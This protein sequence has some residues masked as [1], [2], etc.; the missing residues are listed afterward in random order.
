[1]TSQTRLRVLPRPPRGGPSRAPLLCVPF[2]GGG[3]TAY[4][5][6]HRLLPRDIL[7][8]T[9][10]LP[11]REA[12]FDEELPTDL[13]TLAA[14]IAAEVAPHLTG[15]FVLFGHSMGAVVAFELARA[16]QGEHGR[17]PRCLVVSGAPA[18]DVFGARS[19]YSDLT[20]DQLRE[21][22][23]AMG[24][25]RP[26]TLDD[27]ELWALFAPI[28]RADLLACENYRYVPGEPLSCPLVACGARDDPDLDEQR[29]A[30]WAAFTSG[31]FESRL[32]PGDHF[33]FQ[34]WPE[35]FAIDLIN[36]LHR[37]AGADR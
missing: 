11:G 25:S 29:L 2:A 13:C 21:A 18:P 17:V 37:H 16:L 6:W 9:F 24:G 30:D 4:D 26:G 22:V 23:A 14:G 31:P 5:T 7:P 33:Y 3:A 1:M 35:A 10:R 34:H 8:M 12:R 32:F 20:A 19:K 27:P 28:I 15:P 36:R